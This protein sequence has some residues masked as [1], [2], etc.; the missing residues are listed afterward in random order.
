LIEK[1][2]IL[3]AIKKVPPDNVSV[4]FPSLALAGIERD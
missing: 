3:H 2:T 1:W 4:H